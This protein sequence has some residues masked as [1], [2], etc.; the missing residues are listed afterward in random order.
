MAA[1]ASHGGQCS[2]VA[3]LV[4][5][6]GAEQGEREVREVH[7]PQQAP[8]EAEAESEQPVE[9]T[10]EEAGHDR[11][12]EQRGARHRA[13]PDQGGR[14]RAPGAANS[15]GHTTT[16]LPSWTCFTLNRSSP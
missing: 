14:S 8:R 5:E 11:L 15:R 13:L 7:Q 10:S 12:A 1:A 2:D 16:H 4:R 6:I 3:E 9:T